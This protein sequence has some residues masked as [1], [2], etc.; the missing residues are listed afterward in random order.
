MAKRSAA[1]RIGGIVSDT[2]AYAEDYGCGL[3]EALQDVVSE[4]PCFRDD[5]IAAAQALG[6]EVAPDWIDANSLA[7]MGQVNQ[8][9]YELYDN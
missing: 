8:Y 6:V 3:G 2:R 4:G 5:L 7:D 9:Y 1:S